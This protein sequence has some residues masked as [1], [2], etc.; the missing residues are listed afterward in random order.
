MKNGWHFFLG[1]WL[2]GKGQRVSLCIPTN[3]LAFDE[4]ILYCLDGLHETM[5]VIKLDELHQLMRSNC[6]APRLFRVT[7]HL[8]KQFSYD[9]DSLPSIIKKTRW[10]LRIQS[11]QNDRGHVGLNTSMWRPLALRSRD[12]Q[13]IFCPQSKTSK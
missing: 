4:I 13:N 12:P 3:H 5:T 8:K 11:L 2:W 1:K 10:I 6:L 7:F 9:F